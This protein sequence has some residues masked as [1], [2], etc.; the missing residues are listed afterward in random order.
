MSSSERVRA[1]VEGRKKQRIEV[2]GRL[3][4]NDPKCPHGTRTGY[5]GWGCQC[6]ECCEANTLYQARRRRGELAEAA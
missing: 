1:L 2:D 3:I 4:T 5:T 6:V